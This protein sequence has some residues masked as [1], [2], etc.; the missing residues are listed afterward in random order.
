MGISDAF[1]E[2][3]SDSPEQWSEVASQ[4]T[5]LSCEEKHDAYLESSIKSANALKDM[6]NDMIFRMDKHNLYIAGHIFEE[7]PVDAQKSII[8]F[9][10]HSCE[11]AEGEDNYMSNYP[12]YLELRAQSERFAKNFHLLPTNTQIFYREALKN[13]SQTIFKSLH[14]AAGHY[15]HEITKHM[16]F[17]PE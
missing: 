5:A 17:D 13:M 3:F 1:N 9:A 4:Y 12:Q 8:D 11:E 15:E 2:L 6:F 14:V 10:L 16:K 7:M